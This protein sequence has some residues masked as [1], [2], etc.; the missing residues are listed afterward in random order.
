MGN[1]KFLFGANG[2]AA[3]KTGSFFYELKSWMPF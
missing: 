1:D 2:K 3:C